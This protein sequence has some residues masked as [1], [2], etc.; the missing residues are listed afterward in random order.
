MCFLFL[1]FTHMLK[2]S[3]CDRYMYSILKH[4]SKMY[5]FHILCFVSNYRYFFDA[6]ALVL[7]V[8]FYILSLLYSTRYM[9]YKKKKRMRRRVYVELFKML[10]RIK[11]WLAFQ[12]LYFYSL[13]SYLYKSIVY[14]LDKSVV[15]LHKYRENVMK[16]HDSVV[17]HFVYTRYEMLAY[18]L[19]HQASKSKR[20]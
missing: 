4:S 1:S 13:Y 11:I 7:F 16:R 10:S 2:N 18:M 8:P 6:T 9:F 17:E 19:D 5:F 20:N 3:L 15:L 12:L 14:L